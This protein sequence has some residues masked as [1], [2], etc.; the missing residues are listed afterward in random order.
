MNDP[1]TFLHALGLLTTDELQERLKHCG[2][3]VVVYPLA[4]VVKPEVVEIGDYTRID[5]FCF[6]YGGRGIRFGRYN[7]IAS[8][9][10]II[11]GGKLTTGDY[12]GFA[13]GT[14]IVTGTD[15]YGDGKRICPFVPDEE[16]GFFLGS[17]TLEDDVFLGTN[18]VVHP[19]VTVGEGAIVG[20]N[21]L[22]LEDVEPWSINV[23]SPSRKVGERPRIKR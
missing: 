17:V 4:K 22:V 20:S 10:S 7:H 2:E 1:R 16:R 13:A 19:N 21:S 11:G 23:G 8:F 6:I 3:H 14:R 18:V 5:D 9:T 15:H 12:V